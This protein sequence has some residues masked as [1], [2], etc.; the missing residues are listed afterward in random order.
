MSTTS[1]TPH[2]GGRSYLRRDAPASSAPVEGYVRTCDAR[3]DLAAVHAAAAAALRWYAAP[4]DVDD[5]VQAELI[6]SW[7][8]GRGLPVDS[9]LAARGLVYRVSRR[10]RGGRWRLHAR[11]RFL[12]LALDGAASWGSPAECEA[13]VDAAQVRTVD[14]QIAATARAPR[15]ASTL[16]VT[17]AE[18]VAVTVEVLVGDLSA[19]EA[20]RE[21]GAT[22][23]AWS[24]AAQA[25]AEKLRVALVS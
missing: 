14:T 10:V 16:A 6:L 13:A 12:G 24:A 11:R 21:C 25:L 9:D 8:S 18:R 5:E 2:G 22:V 4:D 7:L 1:R 17:P 20:A 15:V 19:T 3:V 23:A